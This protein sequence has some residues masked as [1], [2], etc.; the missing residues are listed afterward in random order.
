MVCD[1]LDSDNFP[2]IL[3]T[4]SDGDIMIFERES[5]LFEMVWDYRLPVGNAY[6][7]CSGDFTGDGESEFC[8]GGYNQDTDDPV[9]SFSFYQFFKNTGVNNEYQ[10]LGYLAFSEVDTKNSIASADMDGDG[11]DEIVIAAPPNIYVIDYIDGQF[12]P[13]WQGLSTKTSSNIIAVSGKTD[14]Q[15]AFI[16]TNIEEGGITK[17]TLIT[18]GEEFNGPAS[19]QFFTAAPLDSVSVYLSWQHAGADNFKVYRKFE[20]GDSLIANIS[21]NFFTDENLTIGDTLYY[22]VTAVDA[23][24]DPI[25]SLPTSWEMVVPYFVP[26]LINIRMISQYEIK[27]KFDIEVDNIYST[28]F[29][30]DF[31]RERIYPI[32][33]NMIEQNTALILRFNDMFNEYDDYILNISGLT[34][35]TG[36]PIDSG[37][38]Q[39]Q[40]EED[41][42][43]PEII[44][45]RASTANIVNIIFSE[46]LDESL[47]EDIGNYTLIFPAVDKDNEIEN[48]EYF[49]GDS[50]YV[51][52]QFKDDLKYT[53]QPYFL[54]VSNL[55]D[56]AGNVISNSGNKYH[57]SLTSMLGLKNLKQM[58][59]YPNPLY[60]GKNLIDKFNFINLP[61]DVSGRIWIYNLDG[62]LIF[63]SD[64]GQ[65]NINDLKPY[66]SWEC[67]NNAGNKV[68]SGI[69]FYLIRM[70]KDSRKGKIIIIN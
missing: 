56:L 64:L 10:S 23:S 66:F 39:F 37:P 59:V 67:K 29:S 68:S 12:Q 54:K 49:E 70:G 18:E 31:G 62:E 32:S 4:D 48:L 44:T 3:A 11:D 58:V 2:D 1:K 27:L 30:V 36:V 41:T 20:D 38:Y 28:I 7:L 6:N 19:P 5:G 51:A 43:P 26:E 63:D 65:Y 40:Y 53:N 55:K 25:E 14:F 16:V 46:A 8:V 13:I 34:G 52:M 17:S 24:F 42:Y 61:F 21:Q 9:R 50:C 35:K 60:I 47:A 57:F 69:Y 15:D 33:V 45:V 22:Q